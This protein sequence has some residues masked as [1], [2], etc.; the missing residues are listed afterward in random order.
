MEIQKHLLTKAGF[1]RECDKRAEGNSRSFL[2]DH[3]QSYNE[4]NEALVNEYYSKTRSIDRLLKMRN[5]EKIE[6]ATKLK[7]VFKSTTIGRIIRYNY[8]DEEILKHGIISEEDLDSEYTEHIHCTDLIVETI[9]ENE[10]IQG[11]I[12]E[13]SK[14]AKDYKSKNYDEI[15]EIEAELAL[16]GKLSKSDIH[17]YMRI[18]DSGKIKE[19]QKK[20]EMLKYDDLLNSDYP[21]EN[22]CAKVLSDPTVELNEYPLGSIIWSLS[23]TAQDK[24]IDLIVKSYKTVNADKIEE[25]RKEN[26]RQYKQ[27]YA[28]KYNKKQ[29]SI[30]DKRRLVQTGKSDGLT[31]KEVAKNLGCSVRTVHSYWNVA[32]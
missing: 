26:T 32:S 3:H 10:F 2:K 23:K 24:L 11:Q 4:Q 15:K 21:I 22:I 6:E 19:L 7:N 27:Q 1:Y 12:I 8:L 30:E 29:L 20:I 16:I 28:K 25:F 17:E 31:Q 13:Y 9:F 5:T 18:S 14:N